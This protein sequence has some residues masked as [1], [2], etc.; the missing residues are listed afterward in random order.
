MI[1]LQAENLSVPECRD[2]AIRRRVALAGLGVFDKEL[3]ACASNPALEPEELRHR[4]TLQ[5]CPTTH[6][7]EEFGLALDDGLI[8]VGAAEVGEERKVLVIER[9]HA[10]EVSTVPRIVDRVHDLPRLLFC[11]VHRLSP[12]RSVTWTEIDRCRKTLPPKVQ[13]EGSDP[14]QVLCKHAP[15]TCTARCPARADDRQDQSFAG[16]PRGGFVHRR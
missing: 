5:A 9:K 2:L 12:S 4:H 6:G 7:F 3:Y 8:A 14:N 10:F 15:N 11:H 1:V 16:P 13:C